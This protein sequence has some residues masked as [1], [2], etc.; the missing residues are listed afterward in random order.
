[1]DIYPPYQTATCNTP[2][3]GSAGT[4][5]DFLFGIIGNRHFFFDLL[6]RANHNPPLIHDCLNPLFFPVSHFALYGARNFQE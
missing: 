1:M 5:A 3:K 6:W 4:T 2:K